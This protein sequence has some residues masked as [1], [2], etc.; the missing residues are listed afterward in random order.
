MATDYS[1]YYVKNYRIILIVLLLL[2]SFLSL[3]FNI[4]NRIWV[5][6]IEKFLYAILHSN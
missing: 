1:D 3:V 2:K 5:Q 6:Y 4:I